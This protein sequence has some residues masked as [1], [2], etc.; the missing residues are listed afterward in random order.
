MLILFSTKEMLVE[1][2][3]L[4]FN[5]PCDSSSFFISNW[6]IQTENYHKDGIVWWRL[7]MFSLWNIFPRSFTR[8]TI[9]LRVNVNINIQMIN[10]SL[11]LLWFCY[12]GK[13][14]APITP[15]HTIYYHTAKSIRNTLRLNILL[16]FSDL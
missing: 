10:N 16:T 13:K 8:K 9:I 15:L 1:I 6:C 14:I 2:Y 11:L 4:I 12:P 5:I 7:N 3:Q